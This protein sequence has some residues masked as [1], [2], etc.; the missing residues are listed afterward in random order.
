[1]R[2]NPILVPV[3]LITA[4]LGTVLVSQAAG[5]WTTS[6]RTEIDPTTMTAA[7]IKGWMTLQQVMD[8]LQISQSGLYVV[9]NI[10]ADI[11]P[12]TTLK[13]LEDIV[14]VTTL[15]DMLTV[16]LG[17]GP[18]SASTETES[19]IEAV[20]Q[21]EPTATS[22]S[23]K[24]ET[25]ATLTPLPT[26]EILPADQFKGKMSL[27]EV[28]VQ[29]AVPIDQMILGLNIPAD[30]NPDTLIKDLISQGKI[31]EVTAVQ[32]AIATLQAR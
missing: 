10:P 32:Q 30:T 11:S 7:D 15:R 12:D 21:T 9:G 25:H 23:A 17:A 1:M 24:S 18:E 13:D 31:N 4:L 16:P 26:G 20:T 28:S 2:I 29:C 5:M 22:T 3:I 19:S 14:S 8:G 27:R 6:G